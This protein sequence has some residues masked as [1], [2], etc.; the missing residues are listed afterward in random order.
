MALRGD[1]AASACH[2]AKKI[3]SHTNRHSLPVPLAALKHPHV[4]MAVNWGILKSHP[5][6]PIFFDAFILTVHPPLTLPFSASF[7]PCQLQV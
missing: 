2:K 4:P 1:T 6:T 3:V 5:G 7:Q